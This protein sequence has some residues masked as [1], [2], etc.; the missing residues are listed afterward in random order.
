MTPFDDRDGVIWMDGGL[1][2]WREA[3]LHFLSHGLHYASFVYEGIRV[4]GGRIFRL[5]AHVDRLLRSAAML[6]LPVP[7]DRATL[8]D[9]CAE[10]AAANALSDGYLRPAIWKGS[11]MIQIHAPGARTHCAIAGWETAPGFY[12]K[13]VARDQGLRL[14]TAHWRRP[15]PLT[16]PVQAK[17]SGHYMMSALAKQEAVDAGYDDALLLDDRGL[18]SEASGANLFFVR[19]GA[20]H[21][22][23]T[24]SCLEGITRATVLMLA[25]ELGLAAIERD[26]APDEIAEMDEV[27]L[28]G[29]ASEVKPVVAVD[30][31]EFAVG[32]ITSRLVERY[33]ALVRE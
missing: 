11:D 32:A 4:Y 28:T 17:A 25:G 29:T 27:F 20:V 23:T 18:V 21:T 1:R 15:S 9:A 16:T 31:R 24:H 2:P 10:V 7:A 8:L 12:N 6:R 3:K 30:A 13:A 33:Q 19:D 26:I 22:P 14:G 5:E